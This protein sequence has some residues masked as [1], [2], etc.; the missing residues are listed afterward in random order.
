MTA[1]QKIEIP[2]NKVKILILLG[3]AALFVALGV[4]LF[5]VVAGRE[6]GTSRL[7]A[8]GIGVL[9]AGF[10]G[11]MGIIGLRKLFDDKPGLAIGPDGIQDNSSAVSVGLIEWGDISGFRAVKVRSTKFIM[12][13]VRNPESY[14]AK[15]KNGVVKKAME[16]N[17]A[18]YGSPLAITS[19]SLK[20][21]FTE[22]EYL[23]LEAYEKYK[24]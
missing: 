14:I 23:L 2:L 5:M 17:R 13:D 8:Q 19:T 9:A 16:L 7:A 1:Q 12:I 18:L 6:S 15:A 20:Y 22:L 24:N 21:N 4:W 11:F 10:F 3:G